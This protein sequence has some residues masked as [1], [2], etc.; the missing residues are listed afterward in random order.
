LNKGIGLV[1]AVA[2]LT[3]V[4]AVGGTAYVGRT[5]ETKMTT[6]ARA[7]LDKIAPLVRVKAFNYDKSLLGATRTITLQFGCD[8]KPLQITWR[9]Q[10]KHGPFPGFTG[11]GAA[12][13]DSELLLSDETKAQL[14]A[15]Y[16]LEVPA[17]RVKSMVAL[18]GDVTSDSALAAF[19]GKLADGTQ[20]TWQGITLHSVETGTTVNYEVAL[21]G[22]E[23]RDLEKGASLRL[24]GAKVKGTSSLGKFW[25]AS[26]GSST[27][28]VSS[29]EMT[30]KQG[31]KEFKMLASNLQTT[32]TSK[33]EGDLMSASSD[34]KGQFEFNKTKLEKVQIAS[35]VKRLHAP[36][37]DAM[38][39]AL[40]SQT[41]A[42]LLCSN[43]GNSQAKQALQEQ[44][45]KQL[46]D[47]LQEFSLKLLAFD[48]EYSVD[49]MAAN[50]MGNE[51]E[52]S[53]SVG[54]QGVTADDAKRLKEDPKAVIKK[55]ALAANLK[56]PV[57]WIGN[58]MAS[59]G[60]DKAPDDA[61]LAQM[62]EPMIQQGLVVREGNLLLLKATM[63]D[64]VATL[65][66]KEVPLPGM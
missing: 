54:V 10:I 7:T 36:T 38:M 23:M 60:G 61:A 48:P 2:T 62:I 3:S 32:S 16:G 63:K 59:A 34:M 51:G 41:S 42:G 8:D 57:P 27:S 37:L 40:F 30:V 29:I 24:S 56:L 1:L 18:N 44:V 45:A 66:G 22:F 52:F 25:W 50:F 17:L 49:K 47:M 9:D 11:I 6:E 26:L 13:V 33:L 55:I 5:I 21:P 46:V 4:A 12:T 19:S 20:L 15:N 14:K 65:N 43:V 39:T 58:I 35:S 53:Y 31:D 64:G 28:E